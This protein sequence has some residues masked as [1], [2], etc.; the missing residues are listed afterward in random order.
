MIRAA[1]L[2]I[3]SRGLMSKS[4]RLAVVAAVVATLAAVSVMAA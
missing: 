2:P 1:S 3:L 4:G